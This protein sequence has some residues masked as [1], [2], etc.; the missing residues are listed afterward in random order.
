MRDRS[1]AI[2]AAVSEARKGDVV[3]ICGKGHEDYQLVGDQRLPFSDTE[4]VR[5]ALAEGAP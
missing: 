4:Q 5:Q 1:E 2:R 3:A